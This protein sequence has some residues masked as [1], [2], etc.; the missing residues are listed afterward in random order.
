MGFING[1][2]FYI[3]VGV[4]TLDNPLLLLGAAEHL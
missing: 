4:L 1:N 2:F 3:E